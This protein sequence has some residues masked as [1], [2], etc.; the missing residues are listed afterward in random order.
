[1]ADRLELPDDLTSLVEKRELED[2]RKEAAPATSGADRRTGSDR[3]GQ[4][5]DADPATTPKSGA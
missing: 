4:D 5:P 3:R 2:R 1:M